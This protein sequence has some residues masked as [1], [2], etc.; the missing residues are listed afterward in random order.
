MIHSP[1]TLKFSQRDLFVEVW[2][3]AR[4]IAMDFETPRN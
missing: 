2:V 3:G 1:K 4:E